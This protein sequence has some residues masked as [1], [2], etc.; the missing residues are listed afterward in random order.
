MKN[1]GIAAVFESIA[2]LM[3]IL[4][5]DRFRI[6]SYRKASRVVGDLT[7]AIEDVAAEGR[8]EEIPGVGKSTAAKIAQYLQSGRVEFH[9][10]LL[11]KVPPD[12]PALLG[13]PGLGPKTVA[14]LWRQ[15]E[16]TSIA[17][18]KA[19]YSDD[20]QR[21]TRVDGLGIKKTRQIWESLMFMESAGGRILL[22][23]ANQLAGKLL[24]AVGES[25]GA[26]RVAA[27]GSLRR[28][29]ETVGDI[30]LLCE[31]PKSQAA[32][33]IERFAHAEDVR[34]VIAKGDTKGSVVLEGEVQADL[35][36]VA[37]KSFGSALAYFTG[38]KEHN[39]R[40]R[41]LAIKKGLKLNEYGLF[42]DDR[43]VAG[44]DEEGIYA[45]LGL[46]W[47]APELREDRGEFEAAAEGRLPEL[48]ELGDIRGDLHVHSTDSDGL[49]TIEE[50]I[51]AC[52]DRGYAYVA[53][54]DHSKSQVQAHGL[55]EQRLAEQAAAIRKAARKY[56]D[57]VVLAGIEVDIF[58]D[59]SLDF[60]ADVL[61]ELDWVTA[62][63]HSALSL[64]RKEATRRLIRA[65]EH[66][67]VNCIGHPSGR[68]IHGRPGMELD[69]EAIAKAAAKNGV[70]LE[71]NAHYMRLDLRDTHVRAAIEA[72]AKIC[73]NTDAHSIADLDMMRYGVVVARRG[74]ASRDDVLNTWPPD[75]LRAWLRPHSSDGEC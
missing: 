62:S 50:M 27:A 73:I 67:Q 55:D 7:E 51:A 69:I 47:I 6:N 41:E 37:K 58:K 34:R 35:R 31:A 4:G 22:G 32:K 26:R 64:G 61:K 38:S 8:L 45:A 72:G 11:A 21:L 3:E 18:L 9:Q 52:R 66:P 17:G 14:K 56:D 46:G 29:R 49:N 15:A 42:K 43:Q 70:V 53:F 33:I 25:K 75:R 19:A 74:W 12:L 23:Q 60:E 36:V 40:M 16:I 13:V 30:D 1:K 48:I 54:C 57:I 28:G 2:D 39:V 71:I 10:E 5:E 24:A 20:P 65:I 59:G 44:A 68:I 63:A